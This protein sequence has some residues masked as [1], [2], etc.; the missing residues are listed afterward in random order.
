MVRSRLRSSAWAPRRAR[1]SPPRRAPTRPSTRDDLD[2]LRRPSA[3]LRLRFIAL[4]A[5][6]VLV[7]RGLGAR[8]VVEL[9]H[10]RI[11]AAV[12]RRHRSAGGADARGLRSGLLVLA[13]LLDDLPVWPGEC[14]QRPGK[15]ERT[16]EGD[17]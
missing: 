6:L 12:A 1:A 7:R 5:Q 16:N 13:R 9:Q 10:R 3:G 8:T 2:S 4:L 11:N 15:R 17:E 14:G